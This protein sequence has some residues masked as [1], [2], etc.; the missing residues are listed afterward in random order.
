MQ[1]QRP[2]LSY[3][4]S[5]CLT[6]PVLGQTRHV[7][8][9]LDLPPKDLF[10]RLDETVRDPPGKFVEGHELVTLLVRSSGGAFLLERVAGPDVAESRT[11]QSCT[12]CGPDRGESVNERCPE[13]KNVHAF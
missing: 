3:T 12:R 13:G 4:D 11:A 5:R 8:D 10:D 6:V 1:L 7:L 2:L 9:T